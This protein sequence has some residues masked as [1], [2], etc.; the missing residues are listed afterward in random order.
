MNYFKMC[1]FFALTVVEGFLN[2]LCSVFAY[3]PGFDFANNFL[4]YGEI[5]RIKREVRDRVHSRSE[6]AQEADEKVRLAKELD[7]G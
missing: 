6:L 4:V 5:F 1:I 2:F 3:Y 7:H